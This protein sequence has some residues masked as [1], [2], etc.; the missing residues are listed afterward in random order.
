MCVCVCV[1]LCIYIIL[2]IY[3]YLTKDSLRLQIS[4]TGVSW[5]KWAAVQSVSTQDLNNTNKL[6]HLKQ[7]HITESSSICQTTVLKWSKDSKFSNF[8]FDW[9]RFQSDGAAHIKAFLPSSDRTKRKQ[10][11][12]NNFANKAIFLNNFLLYKTEKIWRQHPQ[13]GFINNYIPMHFLRIDNK[14]LP[15]LLY[16][17]QWWVEGLQSDINLRA[18]W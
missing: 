4:F 10:R 7:L 16:K 17:V 1:C 13:D 2:F 18:P 6:K 11:E 12:Y 14:G 5:P 8:R 3:L 9:R 15:T